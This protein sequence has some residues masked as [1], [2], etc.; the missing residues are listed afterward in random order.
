MKLIIGAVVFGLILIS[1]IVML[2]INFTY[3]VSRK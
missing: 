2:V 1:I 3:R